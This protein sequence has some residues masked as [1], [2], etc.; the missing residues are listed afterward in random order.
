M[1]NHDCKTLIACL[2]FYLEDCLACG[3]SSRTV[4]GKE[5][6]LNNFLKFCFAE[7]VEHIKDVDKHLAEKYRRYLNSYRQPFNEQPLSKG[8]IRNKLTAVKTFC[9]RLYYHEITPNNILEK[10]RLPKRGKRL[11]TGYFTL[12]ELSK[13]YYQASLCGWKGIRDIA[14]LETYFGSAIRCMELANLDIQDVDF[15]SNLLTVRQGKGD[16]DRRVP[17]TDRTCY[18]IERYLIHVRPKLAHANSGK[19]LFL[20][21]DG[22][23]YRKHQLTYLVNKYKRKIGINRRGACNLLR[24]AT[25]TLMHEHGADI[26][27]L[28]EMLGHADISTTQVYTHVSPNKLKEVYFKTHPYA[29][30]PIRGESHESPTT[31]T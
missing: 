3:E 14:V 18:Q 6:N 5:S 24:H 16:K 9:E 26:R 30:N 29:I 20:P 28:Q 22:K 7:D 17:I 13:M 19:A 12:E 27:D 21:N 25:A 11:P 4:E 15:K 1:N 8:T 31:I 23:R 10:F 2:K